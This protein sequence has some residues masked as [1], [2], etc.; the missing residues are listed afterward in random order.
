MTPA[1]TDTSCLSPSLVA[2]VGTAG[3]AYELKFL[4]PEAVAR[5]VE[6][7]ARQ[8]LR[9]DPHGDPT[10]GGGYITTS[11]YCDTQELAVYHREPSYRRRKFRVRRYDGAAV[12]FLERKSKW[13]DRVAK[14]RTAVPEA[15]VASLAGPPRAETWPGLWFHRRLLA[16]R[17]LPACLIGYERTA[18]VG[19]C[20]EGPLRLTLDRHVRG[21]LTN[22]WRL[23]PLEGG[24]PLLTGQVILEFKFRGA[25]PA[26]F[27]GLLQ[28]LQLSPAA[29]SKYRLC[30]DA[31]DVPPRRGA[32]DA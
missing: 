12:A 18:F 20:A 28:S 1:G 5:D 30:R 27:K 31:W 3:P 13:G 14:R 16:R 15:E 19:S 9:P 17:L 26:P 10:L 29:V 24:R 25:L 23:A 7:W 32:A 6:S 22:E 4:V 2:P 21:A 8:H 11:L